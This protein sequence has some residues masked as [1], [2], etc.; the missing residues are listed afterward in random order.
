VLTSDLVDGHAIAT[1][2]LLGLN[3][4][5]IVVGWRAQQKIGKVA[6]KLFWTTKEDG[7]GWQ[8]AFI[9][10]GGMACEDA[11]CADLDGDRDLEVIGAGRRSK[12]VKIYWNQ[13]NQ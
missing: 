11:V 13:R 12:N 8:N 6:V 2:D 5:Q 7:N 3:N 1:H 4:R 10:D 9:D